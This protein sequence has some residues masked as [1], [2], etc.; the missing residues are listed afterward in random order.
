MKRELLRVGAASLMLAATVAAAQGKAV[1]KETKLPEGVVLAKIQKYQLTFAKGKA[2][3]VV[4]AGPPCVIDMKLLTIDSKQYC[5]AVAPNLEVK[6]QTGGGGNKKVI[7]WALS[8]SSLGSPSK[9]LEFHADSG[10]ITTQDADKQL[11]KGGHG[12][13][14]VGIPSKDKYHVKTKRDKLGASSVY[15]PVIL[16]GPPGFEDLCAAIDPIIVNVP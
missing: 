5:L 7:A 12:D 13:G 11:E 1:R 6:T 10:I 4:D 16:W 2:T 3:C 15:L 14:G 8:V 9:P